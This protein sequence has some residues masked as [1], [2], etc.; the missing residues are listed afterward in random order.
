MKEKKTTFRIIIRELQER[1]FWVEWFA[2]YTSILIVTIVVQAI[3]IKVDRE[4]LAFCLSKSL[5]T[6][7]VNVMVIVIGRRTEFVK[8]HWFIETLLYTLASMPYAEITMIYVYTLNF[9]L[10]IEMVKWYAIAYFIMGLGIKKYLRLT[11]KI[12]RSTK[13]SVMIF[14]TKMFKETWSP[15]SYGYGFFYIFGLEKNKK[16]CIDKSQ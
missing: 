3:I 12:V 9:P 16:K 4:V 13:K 10:F 7:I 11:K 15:I 5:V 1:D 2:L 14:T 8:R 6:T